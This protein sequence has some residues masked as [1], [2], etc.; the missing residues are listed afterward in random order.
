MARRNRLIIFILE[1]QE[2]SYFVSKTRG[3]TSSYS[4]ESDISFL[5][6]SSNRLEFFYFQHPQQLAMMNPHLVDPGLMQGAILPPQGM[7]L[8]MMQPLPPAAVPQPKVCLPNQPPAQHLQHAY[9]TQAMPR[10]SVFRHFKI[11]TILL[12]PSI[13][14]FILCVAGK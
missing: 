13:R 4:Q 14:H 1:Q 10:K 8:Q 5:L 7:Q 2:L 6:I 11:Q 3:H 9:I 12:S